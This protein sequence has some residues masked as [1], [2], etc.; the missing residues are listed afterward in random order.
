[1]DAGSS[2]PRSCYWCRG[3]MGPTHL[4]IAHA[5]PSASWVNDWL[6][7]SWACA[8]ELV[9]RELRSADDGSAK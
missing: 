4:R 3:P 6:L 9:A 8:H 1:M 2:D 7:C 5:D